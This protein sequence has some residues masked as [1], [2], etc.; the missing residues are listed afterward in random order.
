MLSKCTADAAYTVTAGDL[1]QAE[2]AQGQVGMAA[3]CE[4]FF[5]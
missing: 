3:A 2:A 4:S 1:A 5:K